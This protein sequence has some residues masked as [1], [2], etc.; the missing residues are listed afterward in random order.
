MPAAIPS[1]PHNE[2]VEIFI[3]QLAVSML[4]FQLSRSEYS[5]DGTCDNIQNGSILWEFSCQDCG[6][7]C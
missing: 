6:S 3:G 4:V 5:E 1:K 7:L 2:V